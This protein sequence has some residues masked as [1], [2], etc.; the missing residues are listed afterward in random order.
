MRYTTSKVAELEK[1]SEKYLR[2]Q[3]WKE[4]YEKSTVTSMRNQSNDWMRNI[5]EVIQE[6]MFEKSTEEITE[7]YLRNQPK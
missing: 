5:C 2:N 4:M 7:K 6:K 3:N 1:I